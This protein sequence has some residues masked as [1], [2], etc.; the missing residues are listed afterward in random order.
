MSARAHGGGTVSDMSGV[1][2][3]VRRHARA[4]RAESR[5]GRRTTAQSCADARD[6][7]LTPEEARSL[8]RSTSKAVLLELGRNP[9]TPTEVL[10]AL[11][12][13]PHQEVAREACFSRRVP[14]ERARHVL[15]SIGRPLYDS[16]H[17]PTEVLLSEVS[18]RA[19][20]VPA[21][22]LDHPN[23]AL[24]LVERVL[25]AE[26]GTTPGGRLRLQ[27]ALTCPQLTQDRFEE[28]RRG[29][30][31]DFAEKVDT[32][33]AKNPSASAQWLERMVR[34]HGDRCLLVDAILNRGHLPAPVVEALAETPMHRRRALEHRSCPPE[35][36]DRWV[37]PGDGVWLGDVYA[38]ACANPS[39]P[40]DVLDRLP[41]NAIG[42]RNAFVLAHARSAAQA[43]LMYTLQPRWT[44]SL[45]ELVRVTATAVT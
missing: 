37:R 18:K 16:P 38:S 14:W 7:L 45:G 1:V 25:S 3:V 2:D 31:G 21:R 11:T 24:S 27:V 36:L 33:W 41:A 17:C 15:S 4:T 12:A 23:T 40:W 28:F 39:T 44:G 42:A 34:E 13:S 8:S 6:V 29:V 35:T 30:T 19:P 20:H 5:G 26:A 32:A 10:L 22:A 9:H 43:E